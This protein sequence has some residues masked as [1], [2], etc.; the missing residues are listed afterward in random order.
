MLLYTDGVSEAANQEAEEFGCQR[1]AAA[2]ASARGSAAECQRCVMEE[3]LKFCG[4][5]FADDVTLLAAAVH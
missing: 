5:E 1:I 2:A 3:V 4:G